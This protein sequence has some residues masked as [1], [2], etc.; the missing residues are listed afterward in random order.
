MS[1]LLYNLFLGTGGDKLAWRLAS[2]RLRILCYHGICADRLAGEAWLPDFFVTASAFRQHLTYLRDHHAT[3]LPLSEAAR[4]LQEGSLPPGAVSITFD[5]GYANNLYEAQPLLQEFGLPATVFLSSSYMQSGEFFPFLKCKLIRLAQPGTSLP[6]YKST[7]LDRLL[8]QADPLWESVRTG[9]TRDQSDTLRPLNIEEVSRIDTRLMELGAHS[10]THCILRNESRPRRDEEIRRSISRVAEWSGGPV[11]VFS[12]PNGQ[13]GDFDRADKD[14]LR[15]EG[16]A[17]AVSG[18]AGA[19][20]RGADVLELRRY[21][22]G[23]YHDKTAF[24]AEISGIRS[25]VRS[26]TRR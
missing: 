13:R 3:V 25:A 24:W 12:Y 19:N 16:I 5:D 22:V 1:R 26:A 11:R 10:D 4:R 9:I 14:T 15:S 18:I 2:G 17:A 7:P 8:E 6:A 23:L 20:G 21:P